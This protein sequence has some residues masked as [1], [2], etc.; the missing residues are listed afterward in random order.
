VRALS[1]ILLLLLLAGCATRGALNIDCPS[2]ADLRHDLPYSPLE[3]EIHGLETKPRPDTL[4]PQDTDLSRRFRRT[5]EVQRP[6]AT[7]GPAIMLLSGGG[8]WGAYGV[9]FLDQLRRDGRLPQFTVITG[10]STGAMQS[11]FVAVD[12]PEAWDRL[13]ASYAPAKESDLVDRDPRW[14]AIITGS[15]A[16]LK[17]LRRKLEQELCPDN[18]V[19]HPDK[20]CTLDA[21]KALAG[22]KT[23]LI[24][25]VQAASGKFQYVDAVDL[26]ALP[27]REARA[28]LAGAAL[29][30]AAM[31]VK[32]QQVKI[33]GEAYYDGGV[34]A[35]VFAANV[36]AAADR[37]AELQHD[38]PDTL[39]AREE[40]DPS[41]PIY[42]VR[43]G[44]TTVPADS[45]INGEDDALTAAQRAES[46]VVNQLEVS[47]I[48]AIR[49]EHPHGV[50]RLTTAD[51]WPSAGCIKPPR[52][53]FDPAF[54]RCMM[55]WG[56]TRATA[57]NPWIDLS[58]L[59]ARAP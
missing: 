10:V 49:L 26:A 18:A 32:F 45:D 59:V 46:I 20:P 48:A 4:S 6:Q 1:A 51:G 36:A 54:M 8:Q 27:R 42:V 41:L 28:C 37:A 25:F 33:N 22:R 34:R 30:S 29:A 14:H 19:D 58:P 35:S 7:D 21:L 11:L 15:F 39:Q 2:F 3:R 23:V 38:L 12:T 55:Q 24:G 17:P 57:A 47:S 31:P 53:I 50:L 5:M 40:P 44:E 9:G 56:R 43:N 16:G 13:A 52:A